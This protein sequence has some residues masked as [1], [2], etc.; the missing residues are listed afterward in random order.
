MT[1]PPRRKN[2][3]QACFQEEGKLGRK[4]YTLRVRIGSQ[5]GWLPKPP[6]QIDSGHVQ[7]TLI[8]V[9]PPHTSIP[10]KPDRDSS[11]C[12]WELHAYRSNA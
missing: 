2:Q 9:L 6:R 10:A 7:K 11:A 5:P 3:H 8:R 1:Q 4:R 12:G